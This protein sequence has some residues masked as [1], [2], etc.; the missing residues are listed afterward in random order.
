ME[1]ISF[2]TSSSAKTCIFNIAR[3]QNIRL[4][5]THSNVYKFRFK[6]SYALILDTITISITW[7]G[8]LRRHPWMVVVRRGGELD[9]P[10]NDGLMWQGVALL[11]LG[12]DLG[13]DIQ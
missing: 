5:T 6:C 10:C 3:S 9:L 12:G 4:F 7:R 11:T 2:H 13:L 8:T 1:H